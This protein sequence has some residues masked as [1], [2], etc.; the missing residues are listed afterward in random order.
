MLILFR[1]ALRTCFGLLLALTAA[2]PTIA[3]QFWRLTDDFPGG[4]KASLTTT[5]DST[6]LVSVASGILRSPDGGQSWTHPLTAHAVTS[7]GRTAA[8]HLLAGGVG[9][10]YRSADDGLTWDS[11]TVPTSFPLNAIVEGPQGELFVGTG[12]LSLANGYEGDGVLA[13]AD[14]GLSWQTR[15]QGLMGSRFI[16]RLVQDRHGRLYAALTDEMGFGGLYISDDAGRQWQSVAIQ[17]DGRN[18]IPAVITPQR[19][20]A[21]AITPTDSVVCSLAGA[22]VN[23]GVQLTLIKARTALDQPSQWRLMPMHFSSMWWMEPLLQNLYIARNGDWYS[24]RRGSIRVGGTLRSTNQGRTWTRITA[25]LGLDATGNYGPQTF[26]EAANGRLYMVQLL[27]ERIYH[28]DASRLTGTPPEVTADT[29][30]LYPNP[31]TETVRVGWPAGSPS[32]HLHL[33][34]LAGRPVAVPLHATDAE[35]QLDLRA[36]APGV[37]LLHLQA[38]GQKWVRRV[39]LH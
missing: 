19:L 21:L 25:G 22:A 8:G 27:D 38:A 24:S 14:G 15:S 3:Q 26:T 28:T 29:F 12:Q 23:V 17:I 35:A 13:S 2:H 20:T 32:P 36:L 34:D 9:R 31:T 6:L 4:F 11:V 30:R 10:L 5:G 1:P 18:T 33:T 37:Y 7:F 16:E 39:A